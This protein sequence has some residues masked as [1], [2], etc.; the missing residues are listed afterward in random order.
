MMKAM[1]KKIFKSS[2]K[3]KVAAVTNNLNE[4][5]QE[6]TSRNASDSPVRRVKW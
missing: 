1:F 5:Q 2:S 6:G 4:P 3:D